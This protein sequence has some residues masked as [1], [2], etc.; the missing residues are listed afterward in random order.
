[1]SKFRVPEGPSINSNLPCIVKTNQT[2]L[3]LKWPSFQQFH[4]FF[5][6][7][8]GV[9]VLTRNRWP[10]GDEGKQAK[11][12]RGGSGPPPYP[13]VFGVGPMAGRNKICQP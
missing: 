6:F 3:S 4:R 5:Y 11:K 13:V 9:A 2:E 12:H 8:L 1:M 10:L 7:T